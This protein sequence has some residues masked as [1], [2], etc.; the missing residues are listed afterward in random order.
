VRSHRLSMSRIPLAYLCSYPFAP[1]RDWDERPPGKEARIGTHTHKRSECHLKGTK[2]DDSKGDPTELAESQ[3]LFQGPLRGWLEARS[4]NASELGVRY[5]SANDKTVIGDGRSKSGYL[6]IDSWVLPGTIDLIEHDNG[7]LRVWDLKTGQTR[8][9]HPEQLHVQGL[10]AARLYGVDRVKVGFLFVRKT[11]LIEECVETM[12]ANR[13][14][15]ECGRVSRVLRRLHVAQP[16]PGDWCEFRCPMGRAKCPA[17][18]TQDEKET[19]A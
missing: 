3:A 9:A 7:E 12:D 13:L 18:A 2:F 16:T 8:Y 10:A 19:A 14:D 17:W 1:G 11:K 4:W 5:D 6:D 15:E